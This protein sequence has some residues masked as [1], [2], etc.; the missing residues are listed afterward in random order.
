M[1]L[2][3]YTNT[4][5]NRYLNKTISQIGANPI[6]C[7]FKD[8]T[9]MENP[10][11]II[12]PDAYDASCNY[13]YL[14]DTSRYYYV[15]DIEF[16]QQRIILHLKVDVLM[17]F[18]SSI[19]DCEAIAYRSANQYNNYLDDNEMTRLQYSDIYLKKFPNSFNKSLSIVLV[20]GGA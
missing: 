3:M 2:T 12:S 8:N 18:A 10:A 19:A 9:S 11:V 16:S 17:S 1:S 6:P 15:T 7:T 14:T 4:S 13:V 5:D 20:V